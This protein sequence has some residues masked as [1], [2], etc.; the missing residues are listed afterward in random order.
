MSAV[1]RPW[2][3]CG[4]EGAK[5]KDEADDFPIDLCSY[6]NGRDLQELTANTSGQNEFFFVRWLGATS[7][8]G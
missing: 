3:C 5:S 4:G 2:L 1:T 6:L 8:T 7:G